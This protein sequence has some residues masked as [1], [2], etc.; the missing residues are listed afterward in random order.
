MTDVSLN[1]AIY[2]T[3]FTGEL[4]QKF[5]NRTNNPIELFYTFPLPPEAVVTSVKIALDDEKLDLV[6]AEKQEAELAY[7]TAMEENASAYM[8]SKNRAG[9][10]E[11][12]LGNIEPGGQFTV[13]ICFAQRI[14]IEQGTARLKLPTTIAPRYGKVPDDLTPSHLP[15]T[16]FDTVYPFRARFHFDETI[17]PSSIHCRSHAITSA[18][19][20]RMMELETS[21]GLDR[22]IVFEFQLDANQALQLVQSGDREFFAGAVTLPMQPRDRDA[23]LQILLDCSG[24]HE[25]RLHRAGKISPGA[26]DKPAAG[27]QGDHAQPFR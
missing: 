11:L 8:V 25:G 23:P 21:G 5:E 12:S 7:E 1:G 6:I 18:S 16:D 26:G 2:G 20:A 9:L 15:D 14:S 3:L 27:R 24:L 4:Q 10:Y 22:D 13:D 19:D 17:D